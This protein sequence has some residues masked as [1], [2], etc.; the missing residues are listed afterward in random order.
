MPTADYTLELA[1]ED[2]KFSSAHFTIF[3][4]DSGELLHGHN[5]RVRVAVS[6]TRVDELELLLDLRGLKTNIRELCERLDS[7]TLIPDSCPHLEL[8]LEADEVE[9]QFG[10]RRYVLPRTDVRLLPLRNISVESL[11]RWMWCQLAGHLDRD[12]AE[13]LAVSVEE[14]SGQR[15]RYRASLGDAVVARQREE[16]GTARCPA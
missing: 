12:R 10:G 6:G 9:V 2:F 5:Y 1:K 8:K 4:A 14:T 13:S 15:C 11:A 16:E 3:S 7:L